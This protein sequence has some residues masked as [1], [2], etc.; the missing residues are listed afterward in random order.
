MISKDILLDK[1]LSKAKVKELLDIKTN[2]F[3]ISM[4][5]PLMLQYVKDKNIDL[6]SNNRYVKFDNY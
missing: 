4:S 5:K 6:I 1:G 2:T 3:N